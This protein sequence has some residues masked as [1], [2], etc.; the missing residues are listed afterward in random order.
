M[1][2]KQNHW[3]CPKDCPVCPDCPQ[4]AKYAKPGQ[5]ER[6]SDKHH[7]FLSVCLI[8]QTRYSPTILQ[9]FVP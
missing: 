4:C 5:R 6:H 9:S 1:Y 3:F 7:H 2:C 8:A